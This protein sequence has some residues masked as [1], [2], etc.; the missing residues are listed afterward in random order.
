MPSNLGNVSVIAGIYVIN[1]R[2]SNIVAINIGISFNT[3]S[4]L[5]FP[6]RDATKRLMPNGGVKN[7]IARLTT[8]IR[9]KCIGLNPTDLATGSNIGAS[10]IIAGVVS[11]TIPTISSKMFIKSR[12]I[13]RLSDKATNTLV[14]FIGICSIVSSLVKAV[15]QPMMAIVVPVVEQA[16]AIVL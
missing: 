3:T 14:T 1:I 11:M 2:Q 8:I 13:T 15:A 7:P 10:T 6:T 4:S 16:L 9:P 12:M 5:V